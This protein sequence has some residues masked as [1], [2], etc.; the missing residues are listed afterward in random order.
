MDE[1]KDTT[2]AT[3]K[4]SM[5]P[6]VVAV[7]LLLLVGAGIFMF[8]ANNRQTATTETPTTT[9]EDTNE[10]GENEAMTE[11]SSETNQ[12]GGDEAN[13]DA[14]G[15]V[16]TFTVDAS[17]FEFS[18]KE[19]RV[20][21]GDTVK[22]VLTNTGGM[23]DWVLDEFDAKT[24]QLASGQSETIEFVADQVGTFEYYC[25]VGNHRQMG[26]VGNL[27]VEE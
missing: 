20:K 7:V 4:T 23:H 9:L 27:I 16:K 5:M 8:A 3:K 14:A 17:S 24:R 11:D 2:A 18:V 12:D 25:S 6:V 21:K 1:N 13:T 26:M 22:V 15:T 10:P 19:M